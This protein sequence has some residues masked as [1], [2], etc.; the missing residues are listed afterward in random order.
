M[1]QQHATDDRFNVVKG[2]VGDLQALAEA[3]KGHDT[4]IHLASNP[5]IAAQSVPNQPS[6]STKGRCSRSIR[7][8]HA[9]HGGRADLYASGSGIYGD[10]GEIEGTEDYG[11][12]V[13]VSTYGARSSRARHSYLRTA[14][15]SM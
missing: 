5:D 4:V 9:A 14:T 1:E 2:D 10:L 6:T 12:L 11:P 15:C 7:R 8:G 13:P 3:M